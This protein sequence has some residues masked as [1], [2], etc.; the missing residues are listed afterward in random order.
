VLS[1]ATIAATGQGDTPEN[2]VFCVR[3]AGGYSIVTVRDDFMS[4]S[5]KHGR[6]GE[7]HGG[8]PQPCACIDKVLAF[9]DVADDWA[10]GVTRAGRIATAPPVPG[11]QEFIRP[12][13]RAPD[14]VEPVPPPLLL[15]QADDAPRKFSDGG[16]R[17]PENY[18]V[19]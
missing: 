6:N 17:A 15:P 5:D 16:R 14:G 7:R 19:S 9:L 12:I 4:C 8:M 1:A 3:V 18:P 2:G 11:S 13:I 10:P